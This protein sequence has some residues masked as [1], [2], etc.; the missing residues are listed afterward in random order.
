M[1]WGGWRGGEPGGEDPALERDCTSETE[2]DSRFSRFILIP[3]V[4]Y[5]VRAEAAEALAKVELGGGEGAE[6]AGEE[7]DEEI[8]EDDPLWKITLKLSGGD[9]ALVSQAHGR[10]T[11]QS[12]G[13]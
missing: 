7:G 9:R 1:L 10:R 2:C 13:P 5:V 3:D 12:C 8:D 11:H 6:A 4:S